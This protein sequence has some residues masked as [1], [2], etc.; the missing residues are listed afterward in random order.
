[1]FGEL[2]TAT[3][4]LI[5]ECVS[6]AYFMRGGIQYEDLMF[7]TPV[8]R[9]VMGKFIKERLEMENKKMYPNY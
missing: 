5:E 7:R 6:L 8:E 2:Q 9:Q 1:M 4:S 3:R